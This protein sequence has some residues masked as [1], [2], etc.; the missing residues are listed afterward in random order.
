MAIVHTLLF[1]HYFPCIIL[2]RSRCVAKI[3]RVV[4]FW[5]DC[6]IFICCYMYR[7]FD[8]LYYIT[9]HLWAV[10]TYLLSYIS[11]FTLRGGNKWPDNRKIYFIYLSWSIGLWRWTLCKR[12]CHRYPFGTRSNPAEE[13]TKTLLRKFNNSSIVWICSYLSMVLY[14]LYQISD[15][16][17]TSC[18]VCIILIFCDMW[19]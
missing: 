18:D 6:I 7:S 9:K 11:R 4:I 15:R 17:V 3:Y 1:L 2:I 13:T 5:E 8:Y 16:I 10:N 12:C 19:R 14:T